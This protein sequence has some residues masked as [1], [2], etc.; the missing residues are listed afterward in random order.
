MRRFWRRTP[1]TV[2]T[3]SGEAFE[4]ERERAKQEIREK[5]KD[6]DSLKE[7]RLSF[8]GEKG[9]MSIANRQ[10]RESSEP[11]QGPGG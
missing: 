8:F 2:W 7:V 9:I 10:M 11:A 4:A 6:F 3:L 1:R 5:A